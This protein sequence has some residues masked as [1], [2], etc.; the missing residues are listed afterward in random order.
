MPSD[1]TF[2][3]AQYRYPYQTI[4]AATRRRLR[5]ASQGVIALI[6]LA[7]TCCASAATVGDTWVYR[8]I[9]GFNGETAGHVRHEISPASTANGV[10]VEV[11]P[12][13]RALGLPRTEMLTPDGQWLRHPLDNHGLAT[14]YEFTPALPAVSPA[15]GKSWSVRVKARAAGADYARSVRI[16]GEVLRGERI[17]VPAG[18]FDTLK[19]RRIIYPGDAGDFKTETRID[20]IDWFA[21]ALG[22]SVRTETRSSWRQSQGCRRGYC[23][24]NGDW[25]ISELIQAPTAAR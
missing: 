21:P 15:Q 11:T 19:I 7:A 24:Y 8:V 23:T 17:R 20:E 14:E 5:R 12:D 13:N 9:N 3:P 18:E 16:D 22:R 10:V 25:H 2:I 1:A 4:A 6:A